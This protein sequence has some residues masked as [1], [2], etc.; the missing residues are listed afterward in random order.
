[1]SQESQDKNSKEEN[2]FFQIA[3][4]DYHRKNQKVTSDL[5][6]RELH[7]M[8]QMSFSQAGQI[9]NR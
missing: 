4:G 2:F 5:M 3:T 7:T 1:M 9:K 6:T 8:I